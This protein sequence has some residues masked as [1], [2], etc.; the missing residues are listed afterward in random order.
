MLSRLTLAAGTL[1]D[2]R[3]GVETTGGATGTVPYDLEVPDSAKA[4]FGLSGIVLTFRERI[5]L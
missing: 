1:P 5:C 3:R 4:G 2:P